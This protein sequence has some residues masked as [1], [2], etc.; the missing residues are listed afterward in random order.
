MDNAGIT[1]TDGNGIREY[2][3]KDISLRLVTYNTKG[4]LPLF[5]NEISSAAKE[6]G[7]DIQVEVYGSTTEQQKT[8]D[9]D[10]MMVSATM[11]PTGDP[12]YFADITLKTGGSGNYGGYSN[13]KV[14]KLIDQ[15]DVK[16]DGNRRTQLA[17]EIQKEVLDD[18]GFIVVGHAKYYYIMGTNVK[19]L[20]TNPSEYYLLD[21]DVYKE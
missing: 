8:G 4:E 16:F 10:L 14:D 12:Q 19:G 5:C 15:L 20:H 1:D 11:C 17:K 7:L 2:Q 13:E 18:A 6:I 21:K 9:F 3:G